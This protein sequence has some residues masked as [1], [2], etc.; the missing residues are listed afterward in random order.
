MAW[1]KVRRFFSKMCNGSPM[2]NSSCCSRKK[3]VINV[4][5][6]NNININH[7]NN[8]IQNF[9]LLVEA[10]EKQQALDVISDGL[11]KLQS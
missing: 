10:G 6:D 9:V 3:I 8:I 5:E 7:L 11:F 1:L 2:F 4:T